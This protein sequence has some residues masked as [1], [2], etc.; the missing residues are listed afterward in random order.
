MSELRQ[1]LITRDWV[2]I[3]TERAKRPD[4]FA[5]TKK[6]IVAVPPYRADCPFC[7]GNEEDGTL[8]TCRLRDERTGWKV[9][10]MT[11]KY[12]ALSPTAERLRI[13]SGIYRTMSGIGIHEVIVEH[14]RHDLTTALLTVEE[15]AN[16]LLVYRQR[17][18]EIRKYPYIETIVIF[19][20]H[21]PTAGTSLEHPHSQIAATPVVPNQFRRRIDE[22]IRY[23]D[24]TGECLFCRTLEDELAAR[25][26]VIF[27]SKDFVACIPFAALSPFH[28]W[29]FPRRH[30]SS[31]DD[32]TD[33]EII[34][35]ADTLKTVLAQLYYG[36]N[37]PDYNYSIRSVPTAEQGTKYF[38]WYIAIIPRV[39]KQAGFELGSGMFINSALPEESAEFLRSIKIPDDLNLRET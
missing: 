22:A 17:Y 2:I 16:I 38:H 9:R 21:G 18:L 1:N 20:N 36:L 31:F 34:G 26:R 11:N 10:A 29:I 23:F 39:T 33:E 37:D 32:I 15:V 7:V 6:S 27:E 24:D 30:S 13:S 14:P 12:P 3:A 5:N 19:K 35:L 8:E 4:E 28:I 25:E